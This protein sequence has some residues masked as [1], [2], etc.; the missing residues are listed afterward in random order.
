MRESLETA[1][2]NEQTFFPNPRATTKFWNSKQLL[3]K[4]ANISNQSTPGKRCRCAGIK[5]FALHAT[6]KVKK[7]GSENN[8]VKQIEPID[9]QALAINIQALEKNFAL[10]LG[11]V[12]LPFISQKRSRPLEIN[13][14]QIHA[15][16]RWRNRIHAYRA[17]IRR[18]STSSFR[19]EKVHQ[20]S[21]KRMRGSGGKW[22]STDK[23]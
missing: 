23:D 8:E 2:G 3:S 17:E 21:K 7:S 18:T 5:N 22:I 1:K 15:M 19:Y 12:Y 20:N 10:L 11:E 4:S 16:A 13:P 14:K 9:S 6:S